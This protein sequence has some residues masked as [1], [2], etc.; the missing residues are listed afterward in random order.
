MDN[1]AMF[2]SSRASNLNVLLPKNG[3]KD[4]FTAQF[5]QLKNKQKQHTNHL[6]VYKTAF[7]CV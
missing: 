7:T 6:I 2:V 1:P 5:R 4:A 3:L